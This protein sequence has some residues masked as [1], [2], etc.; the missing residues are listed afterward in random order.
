MGDLY[1]MYVATT[2]LMPV[3]ISPEVVAQLDALAASTG[4]TRSDLVREGIRR[5][6]DAADTLS[7]ERNEA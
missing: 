2:P 4:T 5:V 3:R 6:L 1:C 7:A